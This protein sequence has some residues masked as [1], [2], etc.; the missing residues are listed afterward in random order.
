MNILVIDIDG[1][2]LDFCIRSQQFGHSVKLFIRKDKRNGW[3]N[4]GRGLVEKIR[5]WRPWMRWA[6]LI[7]LT[8]NETYMV[9]LEPYRKLGY[10]IFGSNLVGLNLEKQREYGQKVLQACGIDILP[11]K[12]FKDYDQAESFVKK[13][14]SKI[15]VSKPASDV[16]A[17]KA[18]SYVPKTPADM[19]YKLRD[20]KKKGTLKS[21]FMLQ[22]FREGIEIGIAAWHGPN[23][24]LPNKW[25]VNFEHKKLMNGDLGPNVGESGTV[26]QYSR[27]DSLADKVL[28]ALEPFLKQVGYVGDVDINCI[29]DD[30]GKPWPLEW[31]TR[32][33]WPDFWI[34]TALHYGDPARWM[35][36][37]LKGEDSL[38]VNYDVGMGVVVAQPDYPYCHMASAENTGIPIYGVSEKNIQN[39]HFSGVMLGNAP[40]MDGDKIVDRPMFV[41][42]E[43]YI[44]VATSIGETVKDCQDKVYNQTLD[45]IKIPNGVFWR[46]DIGDR[47]KKQLP[48]LH[49]MG[50]A[51]GMR[52]E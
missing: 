10:P 19:V 20:W 46:T 9:E 33:G 22:E 17:E 4:T 52:Y 38:Q 31:T 7:V 36:D 27:Q 11:Y 50:Y 1:V 30:T 51:K 48:K 24:F 5:D 2:G 40:C 8:G 34:R 32:C 42:T 12:V 28:K 13:N 45:S 3:S 25:N 43:N 39:L 14:N 47:L 6:S 18:L 35:L 37:L 21:S 49:G 26:E 41:T 23:G 16:G 44:L 29:V 15:F